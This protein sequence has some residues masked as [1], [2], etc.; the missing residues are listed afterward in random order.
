MLFGALTEQSLGRI[1]SVGDYIA[2]AE[3]EMRVPAAA[4][5]PFDVRKE[6]P[7]GMGMV[8]E[9]LVGVGSNWESI[10]CCT[11]EVVERSVAGRIDSFAFQDRLTVL[12]TVL[13]PGPLLGLAA[14]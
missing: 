12:Q 6:Q 10:G 11:S 13:A 5:V 14:C 3:F 4:S 9:R 2:K 1:S 8:V 7:A